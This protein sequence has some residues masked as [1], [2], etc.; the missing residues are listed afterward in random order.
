MVKC[1]AFDSVREP[2]LKV[3]KDVDENFNQKTKE[4]KTL[5][6][7][8][9]ACSNCVIVNC[10]SALRIYGLLGFKLSNYSVFCIIRIFIIP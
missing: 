1:D 9:H 6:I 5:A 10:I 3:M 8:T 4:Q 7:L 2:L